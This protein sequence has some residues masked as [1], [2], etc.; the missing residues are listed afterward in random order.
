MRASHPRRMPGGVCR[1]KSAFPGVSR[2]LV[3]NGAGREDFGLSQS[4]A[5]ELPPERR[6][7]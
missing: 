6:Y 1:H 7:R 5:D 2:D 3:G 4:P